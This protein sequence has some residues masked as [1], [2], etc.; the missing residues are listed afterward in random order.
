MPRA[1][2]QKTGDA[3]YIS[4]LDLMRLFQ[5]A[6]KRAGLQLTHT[7]GY[8]PR[9]SVSIA[10]PLSVGVES[11]C[12]LLDFDLEGQSVSCEEIMERLNEAL[13]EGVRVLRVY[14]Q[15]DK[16]RD[17]AYLDCAVYLEYD[18]R[19]PAGG[20]DGL[21]KLFS[22]PNLLVEKRSKN[23]VSQQ[24]IIPMIRQRQIKKTDEHTVCIEARICCQNP[25][26]NP[27]QMVAAI[28]RYLPEL[29]PDFS[30]CCRQEIYRLDE[31]IFR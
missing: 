17:I 1:L 26:L 5:R 16:I 14:Q 9:P 10:L 22:Q 30:R 21:T 13:V 8:N 27:M 31:S 28:E 6:F 23:G 3:I 24:D 2:F 20:V 12:E 18:N 7:Q 4:H 29:K 11:H 15:G 25:A 19:I